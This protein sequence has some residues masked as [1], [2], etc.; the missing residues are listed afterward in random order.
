M[1]KSSFKENVNLLYDR[2]LTKT[3]RLAFG[4]Q[5]FKR[6]EF[7][8]MEGDKI[9][10]F[11]FVLSG[12]VKVLRN[13]EN[14]KTLLIRIYDSFTIIGDIEYFLK[15]EATCSVQ[16]QDEV[17]VIKIPYDYI[18]KEYKNEHRFLYNILVHTSSK[19][20]LT[21]DQTSINLMH[22]LDTRFASYVLSL[23]IEGEN[24]VEIPSL[25]DIANNLG[26]SYRHLTRT[27]KK[28]TNKGA[29]MKT[30]NKIK[31]LDK[32]LLLE[33]SQGNVYENQAED[34]IKG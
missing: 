13:Y 11:Y 18:D 31:I 25:V 15:T 27:V 20:L 1:K 19:I 30:K 7:I 22:S 23:Y 26:A 28:L 33:L 3:D 34:Y 12:K 29:I 21:S 32:E 17:R 10:A 4:I 5:T 14:G 9:D 6:G 2:F 8:A 16:T 24:T